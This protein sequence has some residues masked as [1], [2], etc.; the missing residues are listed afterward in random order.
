V[1][2]VLNDGKDEQEEDGG[3]DSGH[4]CGPEAV[5]VCD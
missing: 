5:V 2:R 4:D 1:R 3:E